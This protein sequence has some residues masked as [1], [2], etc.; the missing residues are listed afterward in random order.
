MVNYILSFTTKDLIKGYLKIQF[1]Q[2]LNLAEIIKLIR[3]RSLIT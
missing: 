1:S 3:S 2:H